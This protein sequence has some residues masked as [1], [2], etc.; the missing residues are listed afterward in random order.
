[1]EEKIERVLS[2]EERRMKELTVGELRDTLQSLKK[3]LQL[4]V[5]C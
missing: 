2:S 1:L 4:R 3:D 5:K